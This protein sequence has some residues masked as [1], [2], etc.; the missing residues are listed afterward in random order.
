[1]HQRPQKGLAKYTPLSFALTAAHDRRAARRPTTQATNPA[2][3]P[4]KFIYVY[5]TNSRPNNPEYLGDADS[6]QIAQIEGSSRQGST[7]IPGFHASP[8]LGVQSSAAFSP[9]TGHNHHNSPHARELGFYPDSMSPPHPENASLMSDGELD[10]WMFGIGDEEP[11]QPAAQTLSYYEP[12]VIDLTGDSPPSHSPE[13]G[14]SSPNNSSRSRAVVG[15]N[16]PRKEMGP[17]PPDF[18]TGHRDAQVLPPS[19]RFERYSKDGVRFT[20]QKLV[21][22][23]A[24]DPPHPSYYRA[25][26]TF[27]FN[28]KERVLQ[29]E[30][31]SSSRKTQFHGSLYD[32]TSPPTVYDWLFAAHKNLHHGWEC[33]PTKWPRCIICGELPDRM[34][35]HVCQTHLKDWERNHKKGKPMRSSE[36]VAAIFYVVQLADLGTTRRLTPEEEAAFLDFRRSYDHIWYVHWKSEFAFQWPEDALMARARDYVGYC[37]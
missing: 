27:P 11:M 18:F 34:I 6:P 3:S 22:H 30:Q 10:A 17:L 28:R 1:M 33:E 31:L 25:L 12:P 29:S 9:Q 16:T 13:M 26:V 36:W 4:P 32:P 15:V 2:V 20:A 7:S 5:P 35:R 19:D 24:Y 14:A 23:S 37:Q 21:V 8:G